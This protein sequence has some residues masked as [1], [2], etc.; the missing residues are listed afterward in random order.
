MDR[1][2]HGVTKIR[3]QLSDFHLISFSLFKYQTDWDDFKQ[4][5]L[6]PQRN[7]CPKGRQI[8][9]E[10]IAGNHEDS[11]R[12]ILCLKDSCHKRTLWEQLLRPKRKRKS[13][14]S[15]NLSSRAASLGRVVIITKAQM[16]VLDQ[17]SQSRWIYMA[18]T[19]E[20][21]TEYWG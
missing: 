12:G 4:V 21:M 8:F 17:I 14:T 7:I 13:V 2:V 18:V 3:T 10:W 15:V 5:H 19:A 9:D 20:M 6:C 1:K 16:S 11:F